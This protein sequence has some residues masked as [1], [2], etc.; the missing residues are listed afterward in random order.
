MI[1]AQILLWKTIEGNRRIRI[2]VRVRVRVRFV[3]FYSKLA[4]TDAWC[5]IIHSLLGRK[6]Y[7]E[8]MSDEH[9][10]LQPNFCNFGGVYFIANR[11]R[12]NFWKMIREFSKKKITAKL[13]LNAAHQRWTAKKIFHSRLPK[14][15]L[16]SVFFTFLS[17]W[18]HQICILYQK[19]FIKEELY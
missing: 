1:K 10:Q 17:Y 19:T 18:K 16:N 6:K 15:V 4:P 13:I 8:A 2:R 11:V 7:E 14:T 5:N 12:F 3:L 9:P